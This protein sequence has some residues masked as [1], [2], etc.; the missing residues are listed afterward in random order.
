MPLI[1][2]KPHLIGE[3]SEFPMDPQQIAVIIATIHA[4][5]ETLTTIDERLNKVEMCLENHDEHKELE[6]NRNEHEEERAP[7]IP[8][9]GEMSKTLMANT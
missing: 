3:S 5:L 6:P 7:L 4:K 9:Q 8:Y 2:S 1:N